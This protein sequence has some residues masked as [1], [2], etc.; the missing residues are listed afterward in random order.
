MRKRHSS[1]SSLSNR[2]IL[3]RAFV[4]VC[5]AG[6]LALGVFVLLKPWFR[7][8]QAS[9]IKAEIREQIEAGEIKE[10]YF[11]AGT[12]YR[13]RKDD[14][15]LLGLLADMAI[16]ARSPDLLLWSRE[17]V[18]VNPNETNVLRL[19]SL[20]MNLPQGA[21]SNTL[22]ILALFPG[23]TN[24]SAPYQM[25]A[26][27]I[28]GRTNNLQAAEWHWQ[29]AVD[30]NP[31]NLNYQYRL[32]S[33]RIRSTNEQVQA[34]GRRIFEDLK[35]DERAGQ[36]ALQTLVLDSVRNKDFDKALELADSLNEAGEGGLREKLIRLSVLHAKDPA[37]VMPELDALWAA[38]KSKPGELYQLAGWMEARD[39]QE[40]LIQKMDQLDESTRLTPT[41][42]LVASR[43]LL[44]SESYARL[45]RL[46]EQ[47]DWKQ[48]DFLRL[49]L[50]ARAQEKL[51]E[52]L[53]SETDWKMAVERAGGQPKAV[54]RL[55]ALG[56][57]WDWHSR[58]LEL[59]GSVPIQAIPPAFLGNLTNE[60]FKE[61]DSERVLALLGLARTLRPEDRQTANNWAMVA[62]LRE[63][64]LEEAAQVAATLHQADPQHSGYA[65]TH[66]FALWKSGKK[67]E[68][69]HLLEPFCQ[70]DVSKNP[71][72]LYL[73]Y[74]RQET[75]ASGITRRKA[76]DFPFLLPEER[77]MFARLLE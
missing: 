8:L 45:R 33:L 53:A 68:A 2:S 14:E 15:E 47:V 31:T 30:L 58:T 5:V 59:L 48:L 70:G 27:A 4:V 66:A 11:K 29:R 38:S 23:D 72:G 7:D 74:F 39:M 52:P 22:A 17:L 18:R 46:L 75:G 69:I 20:S 62:L 26:G 61:G 9:R 13:K 40:Q 67:D 76:E 64:R 73:D 44:K 65:S 35:T 51:N 16:R 25:I 34:E 32:A 19:A 54:I 3:I 55:A 36:G 56:N 37:L 42:S 77:K 12:L 24:L 63:D 6:L 28:A 10:A 57:Q 50:K 71:I 60:A 49:A 43:L 21:L 1:R 41:M